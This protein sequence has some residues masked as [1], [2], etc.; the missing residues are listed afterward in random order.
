MYNNI[1]F[2]SGKKAVAESLYVRN[3]SDNFSPSP[4]PELVSLLDNSG[5]DLLDNT[6]EPLLTI[7]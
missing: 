6:G 4:P 7:E 2:G 3:V 5:E 1:S